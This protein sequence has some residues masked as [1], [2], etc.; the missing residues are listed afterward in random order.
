MTADYML[1]KY[2]NTY[3]ND[4][5]AKTAERIIHS[6]TLS[7]EDTRQAVYYLTDEDYINERHAILFF[8]SKLA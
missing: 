1:A 2:R 5:V 4:I 6:Q 7:E 3:G 8:A